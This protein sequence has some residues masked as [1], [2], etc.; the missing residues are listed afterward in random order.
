MRGGLVFHVTGGF[1]EGKKRGQIAP[2]SRSA[3]SG[4]GAWRG[5]SADLAAHRPGAGRGAG[6]SRPRRRSGQRCRPG[7]GRGS[8]HAQTALPGRCVHRFFPGLRRHRQ[9][10]GHD[11]EWHHH[12][13]ADSRCIARNIVVSQ[14][15]QASGEHRS[16]RADVGSGCRFRGDLHF[17]GHS[18]RGQECTDRR[19]RQQPAAAPAEAG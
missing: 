10:R 15:C 13:P 3:P 14:A 7:R 5:S 12:R 8:G 19:S 1:Y 2:A 9:S 18:G 16:G 11:G 6:T 4:G 17:P